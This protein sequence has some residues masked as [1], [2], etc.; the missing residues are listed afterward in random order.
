MN[1]SRPHRRMAGTHLLHL[2]IEAFVDRS[3]A[4]AAL[5]ARL[6]PIDPTNDF[7][8][9]EPPPW[10]ATTPSGDLTLASSAC[11]DTIPHQRR[12]EERWLPARCS[13]GQ[14]SP[15][16]RA[17]PC[18]GRPHRRLEDRR[19]GPRSRSRRRRDHRRHRRHRHPR[20]HRH[21]PPHV[22]DGDQGLGAQRHPRR[23]LRRDPRFV[24]AAVSPRGRL[25]LEP[26][27]RPRVHQRRDH[28]PARLVPHQQPEHPDAA[29]QGR[30]TAD[31]AVYAYGSAN[32][33]LQDWV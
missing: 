23:L 13:R 16:T 5:L 28:D 3:M 8:N 18:L 25:R 17:R 22:G 11:K 12:K 10:E 31:P 9:D 15:W 20:L 19:G 2:G 7:E 26:G 24:R 14:S 21:P 30:R 1:T 27:R 6:R 32:T 29:I 4:Q 33:S